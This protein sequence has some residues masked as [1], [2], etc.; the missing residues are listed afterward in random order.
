MKQFLIR[1]FYPLLISLIVLVVCFQNYTPGTYLSGW[2]TIHPEF[3]FPEYFKRI[4]SFWQQQ[5]GLG[6][7][8]SQAHSAELPRLIFYY[9][10]SFIFPDSFLR[11]FYFFL[12]LLIGPL[13]MY[14]FILKFIKKKFIA[15]LSG[16]LYLLNLATAQHFIVP[17]EMFATH[18]AT[19]PWLFLFSTNYLIE[20]K[21]K[22]L[23]L[24]CLVVIFSS[25]MAHTPTLFY[26][27]MLVFGCFMFLMNKLLVKNIRRV[28]T[29]IF[30]TLILNSYW[31]LP[32]IYYVIN[33]GT[34]VANSKIHYQ[35]SERAFH[36]GVNFGN[37]IDTALLRN[38][39]FDWGEYSNKEGKFVFLLKDWKSHFNNPVVL[40]IG[41]S[42]F[43]TAILGIFISFRKKLKLGLSFLPVFIIPFIFI[44]NDNI[45][46]Q[47]MVNSWGDD[48]SI[49]KES[50]RFPFTKFS[51]LLLFS[52]CLYFAIFVNYVSDKSKFFLKKFN[53]ASWTLAVIILLLVY[54]LPVFNGYL[55][56]SSMRIN[57]PSEYSQ[58][59]D[60]FKSQ[61]PN[62]R[63]ATFPI[64]TFWG[65]VYYNFDFEGAG[66]MWFGLSQ[67]TM[68]R[69]FDRWHPANEDYYHQMSYAVY[70][71]NLELLENT[72]EKYQIN[73]LLVD[74][75]IIDVSSTKAL[76][77]PQL[78]ELISKS[79]KI[80]KEK[81]FNNVTAYKV[82]LDSIP[83]EFISLLP[84]LS[85]VGPIYNKNNFDQG[86]KD[87]G[88]YLSEEK[89][90]LYS[91]KNSALGEAASSAY[92][93]FRS[94]LSNRNVLE[95]EFIVNE[96]TDSFIFRKKIPQ[97]I[98]NEKLNI[99]SEE[100]IIWFDP[101]D[102]EI[103]GLYQPV[104]SF[105]SEEITVK[106]PKIK[107]YFSSD[108][109]P[110]KRISLS[111]LKNCDYL[112][113]K[114]NPS[115]IKIGDEL[116][117][118][119]DKSVLRLNSVLSNNCTAE[120]LLPNMS[121]EFGYLI[122]VESRNIQNKSILFWVEN[123]TTKKA[124]I[125][126]Y[127]PKVTDFKKLHFIQPPMEKYGQGYFLHFDNLS[128]NKK[129]TV[130]DLGVISIYPIPFNFLTQIYFGEGKIKNTDNLNNCIEKV[131][132]PIGY[133]YSFSISSECK[134]KATLVLSQSTDPG[135]MAFNTTDNIK[136]I[137]DKKLVNNWANG[138][139]INTEKVK[140][141]IIFFVP[142]LLQFLGYFLFVMGI[143]VIVL[144]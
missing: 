34:D 20:K 58:L 138:W 89:P 71:Q 27:F 22:D 112:I 13:G 41:L 24:F 17:L 109:D 93:P 44:N 25:P 72:L 127:L 51:I 42:V 69:E 79:E 10:S 121:H 73:W 132:H 114:N 125:E 86:F 108:I 100:N 14:F 75:N 3:N 62:T 63:I 118:V 28:I 12:C 64:N 35:F 7:A 38:F 102:L 144:L 5:Q 110:A 80:V 4:F 123:L 61:D 82:N 54:M 135:W 133:Y 105:N 2:D 39:L 19:L 66:F 137:S 47:W 30:L 48:F 65:W 67:P 76:F 59:F 94:L 56:S 130:N 106:I 131:N 116:I 45:I 16:L 8:A 15:F 40:V 11:Y 113:G 74:K 99:P 97:E 104:V 117:E 52:F 60:Y 9:F 96:T 142:Q 21:K 31:I 46:F 91:K 101:T 119:N 122:S 1:F 50:L 92:Y 136:L 88:N 83:K 111:K 49:I 120:F 26:S 95:V 103:T 18:Y 128:F 33:Y 68:D 115:A 90:E 98:S 124:D 70:S 139:T 29:L 32:N 81:E 143:I 107:N 43:I 36:S 53:E 84:E 37:I 134:E 77:Y 140:S 87:T 141:V 126:T 23:I 6:A 55:I 129:P 57:I 85:N 78:E